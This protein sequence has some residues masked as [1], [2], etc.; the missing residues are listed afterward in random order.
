MERDAHPTREEAA[1]SA[2]HGDCVTTEQEAAQMRDGEIWEEP[3]AADL[4]LFGA[5]QARRV[6]HTPLP[7]GALRPFA[8]PTTE[9]GDEKEGRGAGVHGGGAEEY[10]SSGAEGHCSSDPDDYSSSRDGSSSASEFLD[11]DNGSYFPDG[12]DR[13]EGPTRAQAMGERGSRGA[14]PS[15]APMAVREAV[16]ER[17]G[18][19]RAQPAAG[20]ARS[21]GS[22]FKR[23]AQGM[24]REGEH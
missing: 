1:P 4:A 10:C 13:S 11:A 19:A 20:E 9:D 3:S 23:R 2:G 6:A 21:N 8:A 5:R 22:L 24:D 16:V 12:E 17:R 18:A 7:A 15:V 14:A